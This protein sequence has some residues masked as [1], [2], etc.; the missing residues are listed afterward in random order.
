MSARFAK[1]TLFVCFAVLALPISAFAQGGPPGGNGGGNNGG[2]NN[3]GGNNNGGNVAGNTFF[4]TGVVGGVRIDTRGVLTSET[5]KLDPTLRARIRAGLKASNSRI[6]DSAELR[7][8]SLAGLEDAIVSAKN[9]GTPLPNEVMYMAGLQ[10]I[11]FVILSEDNNDVYLGGPCE[12]LKVNDQGVVVGAT[13]G[14]PAIHLEDFLVAMRSV[15]NARTGQGVSVS[16]DPTEQGIK[17]LQQFYRRLKQNRTPFRPEMQPLV[18]KAMG[19]QV[20]KLTGVPADSRFSQVLVAADYKMKRLGMGLEAAP[21]EN[22]PSFME[23]AQKAQARNMT[24]APRFWMECNYQ[25]IAR[26]EDGN[27]WQ[28]RGSGVKTLTE[29]SKFD[30]N[31]K[32]SGSRKQNQFAVKWA[33]MMTDRFDELSQ[34]EPAFRELRN[35]MDLSVVAAIITRERLAEKVGLETPAI[36]GLTNAAM[37]PSHAVAKVI[38]AQCSFVR[39]AQ[40]WLVSA[41]GGVQLDSWGVAA[42]SEIVPSVGAVA[43][44]AIK[45]GDTWWWNASDN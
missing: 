26:S 34:A 4:S 44:Q 27:V 32:Q 35:M 13:S 24:A 28:L 22:F 40:S 25:P 42:N 23:M 39:I 36:L 43:N 10:R 14:N 11:E 9:A 41:S 6:G 18:E 29:E 5:T 2:G 21:I 15:E 3:G 37:T 19:Q 7:I 38:P 12:G 17:Q 31:G 8:I 20:I 16:I 45:S 33:E 1:I 30:A